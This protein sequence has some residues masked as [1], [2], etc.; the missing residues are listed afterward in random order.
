MIGV[1]AVTNGPAQRE[2]VAAEGL[3]FKLACK[4]R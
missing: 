4:F 3:R 1:Y 2:V